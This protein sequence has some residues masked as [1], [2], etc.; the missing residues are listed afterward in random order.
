MSKVSPQKIIP[1]HTNR[2]YYKKDSSFTAVLLRYFSIL[3]KNE[4]WNARIH[5][6]ICLSNK[7]FSQKPPISHVPWISRQA[8]SICSWK[9][10]VQKHWI[11]H[12]N[13]LLISTY[14]IVSRMH[15]NNFFFYPTAR[16]ESCKKARDSASYTKIPTLSLRIW[17][18]RV[19]L[20]PLSLF[21]FTWLYC[22]I[23]MVRLTSQ[24]CRECKKR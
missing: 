14:V 5:K 9:N 10:C 2:C 22:K 8:F 3:S 11:T 12:T 7:T 1:W 20:C 23:R 4:I 13:C 19:C 16:H 17:A 24:G 18:A 15:M 21:G 6:V